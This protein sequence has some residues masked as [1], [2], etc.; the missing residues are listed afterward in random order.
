MCYNRYIG[1]RVIFILDISK[2]LTELLTNDNSPII[3][4]LIISDKER[5]L[6]E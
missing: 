1:K 5:D 6:D 3:A 2:L 4:F